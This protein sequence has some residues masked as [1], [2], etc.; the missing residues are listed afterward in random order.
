[1]DE[2]KAKAT[3]T[4][5]PTECP[6]FMDM[7]F[8]NALSRSKDVQEFFR[9]MAVC[10]TVRPEEKED[11]V[12][13]Y[14]AESPDE[15]ALVDAARDAGF[16]F[17]DSQAVATRVKDAK[18]ET[19]MIKVKNAKGKTEII[20]KLKYI[21]MIEINANGKTEKYANTVTNAAHTPQSG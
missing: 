4:I 3:Q 5:N 10:H 13:V 1:M 15:K 12:V 14:A 7:D 19:V 9:V 16:R 8:L 11:G 20:P 2:E 18:G 17:V 6:D 21:T